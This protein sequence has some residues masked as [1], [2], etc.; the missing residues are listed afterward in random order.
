[1][2]RATTIIRQRRRMMYEGMP[3]E[4]PEDVEVAE[5]IVEKSLV[6]EL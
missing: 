3:E 1:M 2:A 6:E 5:D 4:D